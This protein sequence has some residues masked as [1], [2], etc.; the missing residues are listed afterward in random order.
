MEP[1]DTMEKG[2]TSPGGSADEMVPAPGAKRPWYRHP[3]FYAACALAVA[4]AIAIPTAVVLT[5]RDA[6][7]AAA[8]EAGPP[9][10][11]TSA[12]G[13]M[14]TATPSADDD[15]DAP[16][17]TQAAQ[18]ALPLLAC[19]RQNGSRLNVTLADVGISANSSILSRV[20]FN[21][22]ITSYPAQPVRNIGTTR[23]L[24]YT[25]PAV[26]PFASVPPCS[27]PS[28]PAPAGFQQFQ[29][30]LPCI[31]A[32]DPVDVQNNYY[33]SR[34]V[35]TSRPLAAALTTLFHEAEETVRDDHVYTV[36]KKTIFP[37]IQNPPDPH[38]FY[39]PSPSYFPDPTCVDPATGLKNSTA[40]PYMH[41][42]GS[43]QS[44][45]SRASR[46]DNE[47]AGV[48]DAVGRLALRAYFSGAEFAIRGPDANSTVYSS[49]RRGATFTV[50]RTPG[51]NGGNDTV[52]VRAGD[53]ATDQARYVAKAQEI[54]STFF[55]SPRTF[56]RPNFFFA[57]HSH[58]WP[59]EGAFFSGFTGF[60]SLVD[61]IVL[62]ESLPAWNAT[63][64]GVD[65]QSGAEITQGL[66]KWFADLYQWQVDNLGTDKDQE[67]VNNIGQWVDAVWVSVAH[68]AGLAGE[69]AKILSLVPARRLVVAINTEGEMVRETRR[70]N[71]YGYS[72]FS[73]NAL[74]ALS[75]QADR[76]AGASAP[77]ST[78]NLGGLWTWYDAVPD[79][80][81][82]SLQR[83]VDFSLPYVPGA[84]PYIGANVS[85]LTGR[86]FEVAGRPW[87]FPTDK[88]RD[89]L[90]I[91]YVRTAYH[92]L[93]GREGEAR[94]DAGTNTRRYRV[95]WEE[96]KAMAFEDWNEISRLMEPA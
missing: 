64:A 82:S 9:P 3:L 33:L 84:E 75:S 22:T 56:M 53:L 17:P 8:G 89:T 78:K 92:A 61:S 72:S 7:V 60:I 83:G 14:P 70:A 25:P 81:S 49:P 79:R 23:P 93:G 58:G 5:S 2:R 10:T 66:R 41:C 96:G 51:T 44:P 76:Y 88:L 80:N 13:P 65:G 63:S 26:G 68:Y 12:A 73:L 16:A 18:D 1:S 36:T 43:I 71:S 35:G 54:L 90:G 30:F 40:C 28:V 52:T 15:D 55:L 27:R 95:A 86:P 45:L 47:L 74:S 87:P 59:Q 20:V 29:P 77:G 34:S 42:P 57:G 11:P 19:R 67:R 37:P 21:G 4:A 24:D 38:T 39:H 6:P 31:L 50:E 91:G 62:L 85:L 94:A 69:P 32:A 48:V 46:D